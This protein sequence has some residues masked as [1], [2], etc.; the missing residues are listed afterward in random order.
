M[1]TIEDFFTNV[2]DLIEESATKI[3]LDHTL[4]SDHSGFN[5][6][7]WSEREEL[8]DRILRRKPSKDTL[9]LPKIDN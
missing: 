3:E 5:I 1:Q 7:G 4:L 2:S 8:T 6:S 9:K